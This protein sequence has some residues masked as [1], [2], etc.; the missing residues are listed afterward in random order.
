MTLAAPD[1]TF[2]SALDGS[3][4]GFGIHALM[5]MSGFAGLGYQVIWTRMLS[6]AL[7][8]EALA[9]LA[10]VAA[11]FAGLAVGALVL[12]RRIAASR[13]PGLWYAALEVVIGLWTL[14][15]IWLIPTAAGAMA[16]AMGPEPSG[17]WRWAVA[18]GAP[19]LLLA[20]ATVAMGATLPAAEK[21]YA[22]RARTAA[23]VGGLYAANAFGAMLGAL[24]TAAALTPA[25]GHSAALAVFAAVNL[26]CAAGML[27]GPARAEVALPPLPKA[28]AGRGPTPAGLALLFATGL[29]GIGYEVAVIR[30]LAQAMH[31]TVYS[32]AAVVAVYLL[33]AAAGAALWQ[34]FWR[35]AH[36][37]GLMALT[38]ATCGLSAV[39][40]VGGP[41][42]APWLIAA[43]ATD[44]AAGGI[45]AE[46][47]LAG[48]AFLAPAAAMGALFSSL[49]QAMRGPD[50]G[51]GAAFAANT[52]GAACAPL[53]VGLAL[54]PA[55][56]ATGALAV[57]TLAYA[58]LALAVWPAAIGRALP[59]AG[60]AVALAA[61][62]LGGPFDPRLVRAPEGGD[63]VRHIEGP[64]AAASV[65]VDAAGVN[66]LVVNGGF[67][68]G[69]DGTAALDRVQ[70]HFALMRHPNPSRAL[71]LG[72]G[73]GATLAAAAAHADLR[74]EGVELSPEVAAL[75]PHFAAAQADIAGSEGRVTV[76]TADARRFV[77]VAP[78]L[79]DVIVADNFHPAKDGAA[80]LYT[81]EHFRAL[82]D[83]LTPDGVVVQWLPLHQLDV[84]TLRLILRSFLDVFPDAQL[85][86]GNAN[87]ITPILALSASR[88]GRSPALEAL[89][90]R[91]I[92]PSLGL[93]LE[94]VGLDSPFALHGGFLAGPEAL[95]EFA[96]AGPLNTDDHPLAASMAPRTVYAPLPPAPERLLALIDALPRRAADAIAL[97]PTTWA[98]GFA[99]RLE[100][101]W[102]AR[103]AFIRLGAT[104]APTGDAARDA[105]WLAPALVDIVRVS[106]DFTPAYA[107]AVALARRLGATDT[108]GARALLAA[109]IR[110]APARPEAGAALAELGG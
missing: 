64:S 96:G 88:D 11:F 94:A 31:N 6:A 67:V 66:W 16:A 86:V 14:A 74:A 75:I 101:Y 24:M 8:A 15:L 43:L 25:L 100:A 78:D 39:V 21:L 81:V 71:F 54:I 72:V 32:F 33:G 27:A 30:A 45:A 37:A 19:L 38:A 103:D 13:R 22:L 10:V 53:A 60:A 98:Q 79:Y 106:P 36:P 48:L 47:A 5:V 12:D 77:R 2:D 92:N 89:L 7:G 20:P 59:G 62:A 56:G 46:L 91:P 68:M 107:P 41:D 17:P 61:F 35:G 50:G 23:G 55:V 108:Y 9:V 97:P 109:L 104:R 76:A 63:I 73:A 83:R 95:T 26:L 80:M 87:I 69:G 57:L 105:E 99:E 1:S 110:A 29:I 34:R 93:A 65:V 49:A 40:A 85:S 18:F 102:A 51:L 58:A 52:A 82:R 84:P 90:R 42:L 28:K 70:G 4:A 44:G 3:R